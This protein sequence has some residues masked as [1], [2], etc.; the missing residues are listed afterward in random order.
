MTTAD[1]DAGEKKTAPIQT[2]VPSEKKRQQQQQK[3]EEQTIKR[4]AKS[5][6]P[7]RTA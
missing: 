7:N 4:I 3:Y 1:M 2:A 5:A 6:I